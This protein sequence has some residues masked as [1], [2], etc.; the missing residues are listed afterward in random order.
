MREL[1]P[2][3][4]DW[5]VDMPHQR[6]IDRYLPEFVPGVKLAMQTLTK[7]VTAISREPYLEMII[8]TIAIRAIPVGA[9]LN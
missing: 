8:R 5:Y 1:I 9:Q 6:C 3:R 7:S 2:F 4:A